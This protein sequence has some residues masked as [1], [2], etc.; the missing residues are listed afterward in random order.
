M[1]KCSYYQDDLLLDGNIC[2]Q[3]KPLRLNCA[4]YAVRD[5]ER[6]YSQIRR[7][8]YLQLVDTGEIGFG[9]D[10][11]PL[12]E[13][14]FII[15]SPQ[16]KVTYVFNDDPLSYYWIHFTGKDVDQILEE[17]SLE[18]D[19]IYSISD[20]G[21]NKVIQVFQ[22]IFDEFM[23]CRSGYESMLSAG[24]RE[25]LVQLHRGVVDV[26]QGI[27]RRRFDGCIRYIH[28]NCTEDISVPMLAEREMMSISHFRALFRKAFACSPYEYL[29]KVRINKATYYLLESDMRI[30][31]IA[32]I[33]GFADQMYFSRVF[34]K[35]CGMSPSDYRRNYR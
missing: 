17:S 11:L 30:G 28:N 16:T 12:F 35:R 22:R 7:D 6:G 15:H 29:M 3:I 14:Q 9:G 33:C 34:A 2:D 5:K 8:Y 26:E 18:C 19:R 21:M 27:S 13:R 10:N 25:L 23:L 1:I 31:E 32:E 24:C 20:Y 4:G